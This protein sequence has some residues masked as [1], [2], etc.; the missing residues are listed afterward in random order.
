M[1]RP[2]LDLVG[3]TFGR[4]TVVRFAD[5]AHG[6]RWECRCACGNTRTVHGSQLTKGATVSCGCWRRTR[7][8]KGTGPSSTPEYRAWVAM[9]HRCTDENHA[10]YPSYG[11]RGI[12]MCD[13]WLNSFEAF[14]ADMGPRPTPEHSIDRRDNDSHYEPGNCRWATVEQQNRNK[15]NTR[16]TVEQAASAVARYQAGETP[17][18]IA[19]DF[20]VRPNLVSATVYSAKKRRAF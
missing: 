5:V 6:S 2:M 13:R 14:L 16:L 15:R 3:S 19:S 1:G 8:D 7:K 18:D 10:D 12:R 9:R 11:G 17:R 20:G 4:L